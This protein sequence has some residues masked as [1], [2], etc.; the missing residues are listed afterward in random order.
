[1]AE[2][3][4]ASIYSDPNRK[5]F[6]KAIKYLFWALGTLFLIAFIYAQFIKMYFLDRYDKMYTAQENIQIHATQNPESEVVGTLELWKKVM[7]VRGEKS[8]WAELDKPVHGYVWIKNLS[9]VN[10]MNVER[11]KRGLSPKRMTY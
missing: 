5:P 8:G 11:M 1:M 10:Q 6:P 2:P 4:V 3:K 9:T 7:V